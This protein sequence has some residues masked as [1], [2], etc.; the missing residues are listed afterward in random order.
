MFE[1]S[2]RRGRRRARHAKG[3]AVT[4]R[5]WSRYPSGRRKLPSQA[6]LPDDVAMKSGK[7][8]RASSP[9]AGP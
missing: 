2:R 6:A 9:L 4:V 1:L 7:A 3:G 5:P 8:S